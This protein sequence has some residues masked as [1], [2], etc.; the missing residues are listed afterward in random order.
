[1]E[2]KVKVTVQVL[3]NLIKEVEEGGMTPEEFSLDAAPEEE[4]EPLMGRVVLIFTTNKELQD[5]QGL[6][7]DGTSSE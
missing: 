1:M 7:E 2:D 3:K 5:I 4:G 6:L